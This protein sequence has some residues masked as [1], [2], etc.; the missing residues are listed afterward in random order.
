MSQSLK[1]KLS[2][3]V[4]N[5]AT[6]GQP[7][8]V[9]NLPLPAEEM[10]RYKS[11]TEQG[12][13]KVAMDTLT[14][15]Q[16]LGVGVENIHRTPQCKSCA[17]AV[18]ART[19]ALQK[20]IRYSQEIKTVVYRDGETLGVFN[21][22]ASD[23]LPR[24][25]GAGPTSDR[26]DFSQLKRITGMKHFQRVRFNDG[27]LIA[28]RFDPVS[29]IARLERGELESQ[30]IKRVVNVID[31]AIL[32]HQDPLYATLGSGTWGVEFP[33]PGQL[34]LLTNCK[35]ENVT[36]KIAKFAAQ[37]QRGGHE[38]YRDRPGFPYRAPTGWPS[39]R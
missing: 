17:E 36:V 25:V 14:V 27:S 32:D 8:Q 5:D 35:N 37:N 13:P 39:H 10:R 6:T 19:A 21:M 28:G 2:T 24:Q 1:E 30:G 18:A 4:R 31:Q 26:I 12:I 23:D 15:Y 20:P 38:D 9:I 34:A 29:F 3:L 16:K 7:Q 11:Q 22:L 33:Q